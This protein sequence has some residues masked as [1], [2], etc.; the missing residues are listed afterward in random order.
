MDGRHEPGIPMEERWRLARAEGARVYVL[1]LELFLREF[2]PERARELADKLDELSVEGADV[3]GPRELLRLP[4]KSGEGD[5]DDW[6]NF[7]GTAGSIIA[8]PETDWEWA[9]FSEERSVLRVHACPYWTAMPEDLRELKICESGC[10]AFADLAAQRLNR[11]FRCFGYP[12]SKPKGDAYC[13][14]AVE[15]EP[16]EGDSASTLTS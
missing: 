15:R 6:R 12:R 14:I 16:D 7:M 5:M 10:S 2:G 4:P 3:Y 13:D 1:A 8:D 11:R 9:E